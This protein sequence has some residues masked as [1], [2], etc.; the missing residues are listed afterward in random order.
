MVVRSR[1]DGEIQAIQ[2]RE[3]Q[4]VQKGDV[5][6][7]IG[8]LPPN[9]TRIPPGC[10]FNPR[11]PFACDLCRR[12]VPQLAPAEKGNESHLVAC[13]KYTDKWGE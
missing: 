3:G 8:G 9:L 6:A 10:P 1:V 11:C 2:F 4:T 5:L 12:E 7:A 13:W